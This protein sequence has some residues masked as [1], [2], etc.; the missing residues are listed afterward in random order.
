M[1]RAKQNDEFF[2]SQNVSY[3]IHVTETKRRAVFFYCRMVVE[4]CFILETFSFTFFE[5]SIVLELGDAPKL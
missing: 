5:H 3:L 4:L 2:K 1:G